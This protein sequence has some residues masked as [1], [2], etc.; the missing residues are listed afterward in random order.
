MKKEVK[1]FR[2]DLLNYF[3]T[4]SK[5]GGISQSYPRIKHYYILN[6]K[7]RELKTII[8]LLEKDLEK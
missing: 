3:Y 6:L 7:E 1:F 8:R 2:Q 4:V 5:S